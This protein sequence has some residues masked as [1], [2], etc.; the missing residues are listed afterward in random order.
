MRHRYHNTAPRLLAAC[1]GVALWIGGTALSEPGPDGEA[2]VVHAGLGVQSLELAT[3]RAIFGMRVLEWP[4]GTPIRVFVM[5]SD[6]ELHRRFTKGTLQI[7]PYQL[8]QAWDRLVFSG[9]GQAPRE[10]ESIEEMRRRIAE[11]P[12]A[13]GYLPENTLTDKLAAVEVVRQ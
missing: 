1:C 8:Q 3:L 12:G 4:D 10:V 9:T 2:V 5:R 13:I 7:F 11:T 6:S